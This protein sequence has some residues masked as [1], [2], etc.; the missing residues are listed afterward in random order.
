MTFDSGMNGDS[1]SDKVFGNINR[2]KAQANIKMN[3]V[4]SE[5]V[6]RKI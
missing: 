1:V 6:Y 5:A 4:G 2:L 3:A